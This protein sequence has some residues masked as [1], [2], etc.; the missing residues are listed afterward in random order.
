MHATGRVTARCLGCPPQL[1]HARTL[2]HV[3]GTQARVNGAPQAKKQKRSALDDGAA[4][5]DEDKE[6]DDL[7]ER[8]RY[9][10]PPS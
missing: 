8:L 6:N 1:I 7:L 5:A 9:V 3:Q 4:Q 2:T 10:I